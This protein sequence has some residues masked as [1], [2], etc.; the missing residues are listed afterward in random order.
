MLPAQLFE[1]KPEARFTAFVRKTSWATAQLGVLVFWA[2]LLI[3]ARRFPS[4]YDW[5]YMPVSNLLSA[6]RNPAGHLWASMG[7]VLCSLCG[8]CWAAILAHRRAHPNASGHPRG[9]RAIQLGYLCMACSG[10]LPD[11]LL[12]LRKGHELLTFLAFAGLCLG[13]VRLMFQTSERIL[14]RWNSGSMRNPCRYASV[15]AGS[16]VLP[17]LLAGLAQAY[18]FYALPALHWVNLS[19][20]A[21]GVPVYLSFAFWEWVTCVVLSAYVTILGLTAGRVWAMRAE[22]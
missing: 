13:L 6:G 10:A 2:G 7:I 20:R 22:G 1:V 12:P 18:V 19:W 8:L 17:I 15:L 9:L 21:R 16:V 11:S 14:L 5:R 4:E 3:A